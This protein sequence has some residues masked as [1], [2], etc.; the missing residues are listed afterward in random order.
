M[1]HITKKGTPDFLT[2]F[3]TQNPKATYD[4]DS[5][6]T[7][8]LNL[9]NELVKEQKGLCAYCCSRIT[10]ENSHNEHIEP[11]HLKNGMP[12]KKSLDYNNIVASCNSLLSCGMHKKNDYDEKKFISPL[13]VECEMHFSYDPDGYVNGDDYTISLLNLNSYKLRG[14]RNAVYKMIMDMSK[15]DIKMVFCSDPEIYWPYSD[16]IFGFC[17]NNVGQ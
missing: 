13:D 12:S 10:S 11:R 17:Q 14:A 1:I 5:F 15:E 8:Y 7:Y 3:I 2:S 6:K 4:S 9:R 16:V